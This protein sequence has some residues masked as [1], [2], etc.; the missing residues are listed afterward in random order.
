MSASGK[1]RRSI[2]KPSEDKHQTSLKKFFQ[3]T[4]KSNSKNEEQEKFKAILG[5][6]SGSEIKEELKEPVNEGDTKDDRYV[7]QGFQKMKYM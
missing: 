3:V 6:E 1:K 2:T 5:K 7:C 4:P